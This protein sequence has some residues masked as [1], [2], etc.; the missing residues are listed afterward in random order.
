MRIKFFVTFVVLLCI[1][2]AKI[3]AST[4]TVG[5]RRL[6]AFDMGSSMDMDSDMGMNMNS[7]SM[8]MV[9]G[10][11]EDVDDECKLSSRDKKRSIAY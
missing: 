3:S 7:N 9:M 1:A 5:S 6:G 10:M 4:K 2:E 8:A 11:S